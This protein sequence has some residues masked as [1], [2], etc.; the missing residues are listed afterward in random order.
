MAWHPDWADSAQGSAGGFV[1]FRKTLHV[2]TAPTLPIVIQVTADTKY[3]LY[4][5]QRPIF[6]GPIKGDEHLWFYDE[7]VDV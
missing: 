4:I 6:S 3:K 7:R 2:E 5:D 1:H